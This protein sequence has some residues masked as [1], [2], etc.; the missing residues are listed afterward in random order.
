MKS[1]F[2]I[3]G[4]AVAIGVGE[5]MYIDQAINRMVAAPAVPYS[6]MPLQWPADGQVSGL[7]PLNY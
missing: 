4:V 1:L 7:E 3:M 2:V 6:V 5:A